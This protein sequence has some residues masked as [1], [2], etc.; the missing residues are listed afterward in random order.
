VFA[1]SSQS[2]RLL[3]DT[4]A[5]A[6]ERALRSWRANRA[7]ASFRVE[8][9]FEIEADEMV[10]RWVPRAGATFQPRTRCC[11]GRT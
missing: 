3:V 5:G 4:W 10:R 8:Y 2:K 11:G 1:G 9:G 7:V 6:C